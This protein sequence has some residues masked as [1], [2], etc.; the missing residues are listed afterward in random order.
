LSSF[1]R[2]GPRPLIRKLGMKVRIRQ[3]NKWFL[4]PISQGFLA[5]KAGPLNLLR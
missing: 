2:F 1:L 3:R 4:T 5:L